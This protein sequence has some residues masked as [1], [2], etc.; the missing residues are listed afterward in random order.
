MGK[1]FFFFKKKKQTRSPVIHTKYRTPYST[2]QISFD[3]V[4][5]QN[6]LSAKLLQLWAYFDNRDL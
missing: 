3:H 1:I 6:Q 5:Q 2:W 4:A